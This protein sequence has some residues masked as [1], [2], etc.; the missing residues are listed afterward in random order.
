MTAQGLLPGMPQA[1]GEAVFA[2]PWMAQAFAMTLA[3][4][5]GGLFTWVEWADALARQIGASP[6]VGDADVAAHGAETFYRQ[7]LAALEAL[8]SEKGATSKDE[9]A[10]WRDAWDRAAKRT[11][12]G[13]PIEL[14]PEY[15]AGA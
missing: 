14:R 4:H 13:Q 12:H 15:F 8:V 11:A 10:R 7:W 5:Q 2:Q 3:L 9:L 1:D 6:A